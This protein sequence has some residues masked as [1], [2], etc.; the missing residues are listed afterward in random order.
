MEEIGL[1][2][3]IMRK[4]RSIYPVCFK[5]EQVEK[6]TLNMILENANLAPTHAKTEPWRFHIISSDSKERF[7]LFMQD[8]YKMHFSE[9][10]FNPRKYSKIASKISSSSFTIVI[11]MHRDAAERIPEWEE[12][13][14]VACAVQNIYLSVAAAGLAGYWSTPGYFIKRA[15]GFFNMHEQE[16]CLGLFYLGKPN[17]ELPEQ[18]QKGDV[19]NKI[20]WY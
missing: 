12:I 2:N 5:D 14:A 1:L 16:R 20:K 4:R 19:A 6:E 15:K 13:A 17:E 7:T 11:S 18:A 8:C 10:R 3:D 9:D